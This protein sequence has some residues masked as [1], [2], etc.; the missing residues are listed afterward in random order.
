MLTELVHQNNC[1]KNN[2][3][4]DL[5]TGEIACDNCG[6]VSNEKLVDI[7]P[8]NSRKSGEYN[9]SSSRVGN[10]ISF[11][12]ADMGLSTIIEAKNKDAAGKI[13]SNENRR[14]FYRLRMWDRNSRYANSIQSYQKAFIL[15]DGMRTKLALPEAVVEHTAFLFRKITAK[16]LLSGRTTSGIIC[17]TIYLACRMTHTP[18]TLHDVAKAGN[19]KRKNLQG[20]YRF[21]ANELGIHPVTYHPREF[22]SR[23]SKKINV[24]EKTERI[25]F[26]IV[27][28]CEKKGISTSKNPM[29]IAAAAVR[30][31]VVKNKEKVSQG[32]ISEASGIS[33]VTIRHRAKETKKGLGGEI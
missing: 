8:E 13:L 9:N 5:S 24:S 29:S 7:G 27:S 3:I 12:M 4:T 23:I 21:L 6:A 14:M 10:K 31:A 17:A 16:K 25:A 22:V 33:T 30:L 20:I 18:R 11:K 2:I 19:L 26:Q 28:L 32:K 1:K 15:L